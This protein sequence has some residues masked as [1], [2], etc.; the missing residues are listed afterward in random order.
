[1]PRNK[2]ILELD[3]TI[4]AGILALIAYVIF[5]DQSN[6]PKKDDTLFDFSQAPGFIYE[7][8]LETQTKH[9]NIEE[10]KDSLFDILLNKKRVTKIDIEEGKGL[11]AL[12]GDRVEVNYSVSSYDGSVLQNTYETNGKINMTLGKGEY[13]KGLDFI[14]GGMKENGKRQAIVPFVLAEGLKASIDKL[15]PKKKLGVMVDLYKVTPTVKDY[16][17]TPKF[18][19]I[20]EGSDNSIAASCGG[21]VSINYKIYS[22]NGTLIDEKSM[23]E[24]K[25]GEG[26]SPIGLDQAI[27]GMKAGETRF[28]AVPPSHIKYS[29]KERVIDVRT[30]SF[31]L[32]EVKLR[33]ADLKG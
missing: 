5:V 32:I 29:H 1:M 20:T 7:N 14:I 28:I 24:L 16:I 6:A 2:K 12:C 27:S 21:I 33:Y 15:D 19:I 11:Q 4:K 10:A 9:I 17:M 13:M 8:S 22:S 26:K 31:L 3:W 23:V 18:S 25:L 30:D